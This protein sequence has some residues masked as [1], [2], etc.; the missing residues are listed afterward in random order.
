MPKFPWE[1]ND[2]K[3]IWFSPSLLNART[4]SPETC[5]LKPIQLL[6]SHE[7]VRNHLTSVKSRFSSSG[8]G[9]K[10]ISSVCFKGRR[11]SVKLYK[12][13]VVE[14]LNWRRE[15]IISLLWDYLKHWIMTKSHLKILECFKR[16]NRFLVYIDFSM[17]TKNLS[18]VTVSK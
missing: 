8:E 16:V 10:H 15:E 7:T 5:I 13:K 2:R 1:E 3:I 12:Q 18:G 17:L 11:I 6:R 9:D 4:R 14:L